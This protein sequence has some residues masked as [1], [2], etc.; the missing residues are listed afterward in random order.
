MRTTYL[1]V[2]LTVLWLF[3]LV[4]AL[5]AGS[6]PSILS[7]EA[8]EKL[9]KKQII[10]GFQYSGLAYLGGKLYASCNLGLLEIEGASPTN[11]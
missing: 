3:S 9:A 2:L 4:P 11:L 6:S 1:R 10:H 7:V 8:A 5:K